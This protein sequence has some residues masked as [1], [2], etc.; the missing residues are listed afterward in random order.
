MNRRLLIVALAAGPVAFAGCKGDS[1]KTRRTGSAAPVEMITQPEIGDGSGGA[2]TM[3]DEIEPNDGEDVATPVTLGATARGR[4]SSDSDADY[5][6]LDVDKAG[7]LQVTL[8]GIEG[9]DLSLELL[10]GSGASLGKSERVGARIKEGIPN[11]G[12]SPGKYTLVVRQVVKKKPKPK[13]S[14]GKKGAA[15]AGSG[16]AAGAGDAASAPIYELVA[17]LVPLPAGAEREPDDDRGTA[18]DLIVSENAVGFVGWADDK[19]VWKLSVETLS[20]KN[21]LDVQISAVEGVGLELEITDGIGT[22][23]ATR[24]ALRGQ[25][26]LVQNMLPVVAD[27]AP[28]FYYLTVSGDRSNPETSYTLH[29]TAQVLGPDPELEPNDNADKPQMIAADRTVVHASWTPGDVDCF[30]LPPAD[31][32]RTVEFSIDTPADID[33]AAEILVDGTS[34]T[35]VD[36]GKKGVLEKIS[37]PVP[38]GAKVVLRVRNPDTKATIAAK[39]DVTV[40][41][42]SGTGDNAP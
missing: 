34:V 39:Y 28:P 37:A 4:V 23:L 25:P 24:K 11:A 38:A 12:V 3:V 9:V 14:K 10:D 19:D 13:K 29:A 21:A 18:N 7:V 2:G 6:R 31:A 27:G 32:E 16:S 15:E 41:E 35:K 22:V 26:L 40:A 20:D 33:L 42:S 30:T 17:Q 36:K 8:S 1:T 5:Y